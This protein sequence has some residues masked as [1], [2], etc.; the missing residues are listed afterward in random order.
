MQI[1]HLASEPVFKPK[2]ETKYARCL[3]MLAKQRIIDRQ[4]FREKYAERIKKAGGTTH[5]ANH[6]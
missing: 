4:K 3:A 1:V 6:K 5:P 2:R